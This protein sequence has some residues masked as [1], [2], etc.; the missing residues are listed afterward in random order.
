MVIEP[1]RDSPFPDGLHHL[2]A[3]GDYTFVD[4]K[5]SVRDGFGKDR[6]LPAGDTAALAAALAELQN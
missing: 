2:S 3:F 6:N 5:R 4:G 1:R